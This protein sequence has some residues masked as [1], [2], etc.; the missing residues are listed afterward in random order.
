[1]GYTLK[2]KEEND[3][4][5]LNLNTDFSFSIDNN[6]EEDDYE[7]IKNSIYKLNIDSEEKAHIINQINKLKNKISLNE[8]KKIEKEISLFCQKYSI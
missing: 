8:R 4:F 1:M 6:V 3:L 5:S 2:N 7:S